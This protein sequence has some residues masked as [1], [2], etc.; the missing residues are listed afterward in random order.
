MAWHRL[1]AML[2]RRSF[3][4]TAGA[5]AA[6]LI[7]PATA[8]GTVDKAAASERVTLGLIGAG[9]KGLD[10]MGDFSRQCKEVQFVAVADPDKVH[11]NKGKALAEKLFGKGCETYQ[12]FRHLCARKDIDAV[13]VATPDHWHALACLEAIRSGKDVYG[14]KPVTHLFG[15]GQVL[16]REVAK[17][18][19]I[20]Q[21]GSQQRSNPFFRKAVEVVMN[22]LIGKVKEVHVGLPTGESS[23]VEG[24]VAKAVPGHLDY[25][26][27]CGPSRKLPFHPDRLHFKWRWAL[28]YGGGNLMDWIGHHNDIAHW[29]LGV[30]KGGPVRVEAQ[31]FRYPEKGI[32]DSPIDYTVRSEYEGGAT[33]VISN[34]VGRGV[35]FFGEDGWVY[36]DRRAFQASNPEW[37]R[38]GFDPGKAR[39][40]R[41]PD[42]RRNFVD[43]VLTRKECICPAETGHRSI[44]P[45]HLGYVSDALKRPL[46]WD[47]KNEKVVGDS[48]ADKLLKKIDYRGDWSLGA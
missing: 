40:Y 1:K 42:H 34:K 25:D 4:K 2:K 36:A 45:G 15:E 8:L 38:E 11:A 44:T 33:V 22:G 10:L 7:I 26:L 30:D 35:R 18:K 16:Y 19:R 27:W 32:Y 41:S 6:P 24:N 14:E 46:K 21:V 5:I 43:G 37:T 39:A 20:F 12:D 17:H 29:G 31:N 28:D 23:Q 9:G 13:V 47:A 48:E 3:L